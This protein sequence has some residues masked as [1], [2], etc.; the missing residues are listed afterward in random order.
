MM[1]D[2]SPPSIAERLDAKSAVQWESK[3]RG[4]LVRHLRI[5]FVESNVEGQD[6]DS[7]WSMEDWLSGGED[8]HETVVNLVDMSQTDSVSIETTSMTAG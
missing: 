6:E 5:R 3:V 8:F 2:L 1:L 4:E 7:V